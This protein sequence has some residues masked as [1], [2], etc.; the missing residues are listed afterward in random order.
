M[1]NNAR[2][3]LI[4]LLWSELT[5]D[6]QSFDRLDAEPSSELVELIETQWDAFRSAAEAVGFDADEHID[7]A[8]HP[9][10]E[11]D[12]WNAVAHDFILTRN[13]HG[14]GFWDS[15]RWHKPWDRRLTSLAQ[16]FGELHCYLNDDGEI[17]GEAL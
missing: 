3:A 5:D 11:G 6:G 16:W 12:A 9:D 4:A 7:M 1:N 13:G 10:N 17:C 8:L 14:T 2:H 15:G